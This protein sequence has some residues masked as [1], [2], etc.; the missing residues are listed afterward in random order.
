MMPSKVDQRRLR[1]GARAM[2]LT[3]VK[4]LI[5]KKEQLVEIADG[6]RALQS[7]D[8]LGEEANERAWND[9]LELEKRHRK[10]EKE[11]DELESQGHSS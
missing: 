5:A 11:I 6:I 4:S 9:M 1:D 7:L 8:D 2:T 3:E 10:L